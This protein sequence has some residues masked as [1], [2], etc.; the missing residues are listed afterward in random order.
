MKKRTTKI[1]IAG[2]VA[3]LVFLSGGVTETKYNALEQEYQQ[4]Q[5]ALGAD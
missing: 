2:T 4:L 3:S 5:A 1:L